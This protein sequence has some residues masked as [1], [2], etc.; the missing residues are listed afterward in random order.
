[1]Q[2][3]IPAPLRRATFGPLDLFKP[4]QRLPGVICPNRSSTAAHRSPFRSIGFGQIKLV[5]PRLTPH[6]SHFS[7]PK[8]PGLVVDRLL[9]LLTAFARSSKFLKNWRAR[10]GSNP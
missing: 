10:E 7:I 4:W 6:P 9:A 5:R 3:P 1:M 8:L 2:Q